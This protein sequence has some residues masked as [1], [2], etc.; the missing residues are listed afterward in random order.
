MNRSDF[1]EGKTL[2]KWPEPQ[3]GPGMAVSPFVWSAGVLC[4][5]FWALLAWVAFA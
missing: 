1:N 5:T 4:L 2:P 3:E